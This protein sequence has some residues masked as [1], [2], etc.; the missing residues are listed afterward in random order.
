MARGLPAE[1]IAE[2]GI[3]KKAWREYRKDLAAETKSPSRVRK[4]AKNKK[5]SNNMTFPLTILIGILNS[6]FGQPRYQWQSPFEAIRKGDWQDAMKVS[7]MGWTGYD[8]GAGKFLQ[9]PQYPI[10][11]G[12]C[13]LVH[14]YIGGKLGINRALGRAKVPLLRV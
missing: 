3:S 11:L 14:K 9:L 6:I 4:T 10:V 1:Y 2:Y 8:Y 7:V 5:R 13:G 12:L